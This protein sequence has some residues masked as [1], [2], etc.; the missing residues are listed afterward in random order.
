MPDNTEVVRQF[1]LEVINKHDAGARP[2]LV[3]PAFTAYFGGMP[4]LA[5]GEWKQMAAG[6]FGG[7]PDL[8]LQIEDEVASGDRVAVRWTWTGT[9]DGDFMGVP[10]T[11]K[12]VRSAGMGIYQVV[13]GKIVAEWVFEDMFGIMQQLGAD[14]AA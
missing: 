10:K 4:P 9:N 11:G 7:F 6:F 2:D 5:L 13:D 8:S 3:D 12:T 14:P 1:L